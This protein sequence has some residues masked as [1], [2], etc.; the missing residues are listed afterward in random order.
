[1]N[2]YLAF[3]DST[4]QPQ[5]NGSNLTATGFYSTIEDIIVKTMKIT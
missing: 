5:R 2:D 3:N 4:N 1:M